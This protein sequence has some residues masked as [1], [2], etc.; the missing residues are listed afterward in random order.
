MFIE[1][2]DISK[3]DTKNTGAICANGGTPDGATS[4]DK[5]EQHEQF[6]AR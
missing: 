5:E 3:E 2:D 1:Y 4:G 6:R